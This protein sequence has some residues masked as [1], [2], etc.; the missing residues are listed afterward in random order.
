MWV[1]AR[2]Q[3]TARPDWYFVM[4]HAHSATERDRDA[5]IGPPAVVFHEALTRRAADDPRFF[6]HYVTAREMVNLILAAES[7]WCGSVDEARD[8]ALTSGGG[9]ARP[10][11]A[12][13][14][15]CEAIP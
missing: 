8:F 14:E 3:I 6:V 7:G 11:P 2:V 13:A 12:A 9:V 5:L 4:L 15:R 10:E 1:K